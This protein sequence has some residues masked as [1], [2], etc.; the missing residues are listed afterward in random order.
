[1]RLRFLNTDDASR[2]ASLAADALGP[3]S[4]IV[5]GSEEGAFAGLVDE[6]SATA[7]A[8]G[9]DLAGDGGDTTAAAVVARALIWHGASPALRRNILTEPRIRRSRDPLTLLTTGLRMTIGFGRLPRAGATRLLLLGPAAAGKTTLLGKLAARG[10]D[11][12]D[13]QPAILTTDTD[14]AGG[15]EHLEMIASV[16]GIRVWPIDPTDTASAGFVALVS[17]TVLIDTAPITAHDAAGLAACARLA[18][19]SAAEPVL[20]LPADMGGIEAAALAHAAA[21]IGVRRFM[22]TRLELAR[23]LA[24]VIAAAEAGLTLIGGAVTPHFAYGLR[25]FTP[26]LLA[27]RLLTTATADASWHD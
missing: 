8:A 11:G 7:I 17:K 14:R 23:R 16:L 20:V 12:I 22:V 9:G 2:A 21:G 10:P 18:M 4:H 5:E 24:P 1:M 26:A 15:V 3:N 19:R 25:P 27:R 6:N 13:R